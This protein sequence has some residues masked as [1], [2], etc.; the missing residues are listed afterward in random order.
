MDILKE[1][2]FS[3]Y[4]QSLCLP[5]AIGLDSQITKC[6]VATVVGSKGSTTR[7]ER[8]SNFIG[9]D[10]CWMWVK[11]LVIP[12]VYQYTLATLALDSDEPLVAEMKSI[13][14]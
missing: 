13:A 9:L 3:V 4:Q 6:E 5:F 2:A 10:I 1:V 11:Y 14:P 7:R 8:T 12:V